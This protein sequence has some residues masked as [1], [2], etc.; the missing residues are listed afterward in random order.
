MKLL[1]VWLLVLV[2][3]AISGTATIDDVRVC[4]LNLDLETVKVCY[5]KSTG[6]QTVVV[7]SVTK[8][9]RINAKPF[10]KT[11]ENFTF[12][13]E[14]PS[15]PSGEKQVSVIL[16]K[17]VSS[18]ELKFPFPDF[19]SNFML[20]GQ[21]LM[22]K[23]NGEYYL[24]S[25]PTGPGQLFSLQN[26]KLTHIPTKQEFTAS[27]Y[28]G[29][30]WY[31]FTVLG[32]YKIGV[33]KAGDEIVIKSF[34]PEEKPAAYVIPYNLKDRF[35]VQFSFTEP[36]KIVDPTEVGILTDCQDDNSADPQQ[37]LVCQDNTNKFTLKRNNLTREHGKIGDYPNSA[38]FF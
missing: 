18:T 15:S 12:L 9:N 28:P 7:D 35:E 32:G 30:N 36:V 25:H 10:T 26:L 16:T 13:Y 4:D 27:N 5:T 37:V 20:G 8:L 17:N 31:T 22:L 24:L 1:V 38:Y 23:L 34:T 21:R 3:L 2:V 29:T 6:P 11:P 33:T 19:A 14:Q